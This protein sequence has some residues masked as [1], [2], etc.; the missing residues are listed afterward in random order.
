MHE[1][2][3][4]DLKDTIEGCGIDRQSDLLFFPGP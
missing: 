2:D 3:E 1:D 4:E